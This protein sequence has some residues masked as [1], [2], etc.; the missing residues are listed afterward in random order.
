LAELSVLGNTSCCSHQV[1]L[2]DL[3]NTFD[4]LH[5]NKLLLLLV[6]N[7]FDRTL[8]H[9]AGNTGGK[10]DSD[11]LGFKAQPNTSTSMH[12]EQNPHPNPFEQSSK[13]SQ[14]PNPKCHFIEGFSQSFT[15]CSQCHYSF[16]SQCHVYDCYQ[17]EERGLDVGLHDMFPNCQIFKLIQNSQ[18]NCAEYEIET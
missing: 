1:S 14:C 4:E 5:L 2:L 18:T 6:T 13:L 8:A 15:S 10:I 17:G 16:C 11:N 7:Y 9:D 12:N 3:Y